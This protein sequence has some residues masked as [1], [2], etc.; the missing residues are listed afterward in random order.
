GAVA[1]PLRLEPRGCGGSMPGVDAPVAQRVGACAASAASVLGRSPAGARGGAALARPA[2]APR[3][4]SP[5]RLVPARAR[6]PG[7]AARD[8]HSLPGRG[9]APRPP[10]HPADR[11]RGRSLAEAL[12]ADRLLRARGPAL[13]GTRRRWPLT[14]HAA[15]RTGRRRSLA[16]RRDARLG[17]GSARG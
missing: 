15:A 1:H 16:G 13:L 9:V 4:R 14:P 12:P 5:P 8:R 6:A 11:R 17:G 3:S 10:D 7:L 2:D